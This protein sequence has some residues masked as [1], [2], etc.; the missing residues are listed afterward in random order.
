[1]DFKKLTKTYKRFFS[2]K[3]YIQLLKTKPGKIGSKALYTSL[4]LYYA[5]KRTETPIWAKNI[6]V[7]T[8][9]YLISPI[10]LLPD[11]TPVLGYTDDLGLLSFGLVTI[12][13][14]INKDVKEKAVH[15]LSSWF[16]NWDKEVAIEVD[17]V[18]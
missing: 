10:D 18:L 1:M 16:P 15:Q 13:S 14:F 8:L 11:L 7:G 17:S 3:K 6:I 4:L 5:F 12:A 2:Q 9:G